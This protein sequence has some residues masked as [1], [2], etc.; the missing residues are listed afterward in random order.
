VETAC[1]WA[2]VHA[3]KEVPTPGPLNVST[4]FEDLPDPRRVGRN[5]KHQL[6]DVLVLALS[7]VIP[8]CES[9]REI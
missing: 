6:I 3:D 4:F 8:G 2:A 7:W 5:K 9:A 1:K